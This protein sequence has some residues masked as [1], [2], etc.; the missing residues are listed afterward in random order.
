[1]K[2][3]IGVISLALIIGGGLAFYFLHNHQK[4]DDD[5]KTSATAFQVGVFSKLENANKNAQKN[6]GVVIED[7]D[8]Y[9]VYIALSTRED[10]SQK[11]SQ[12]YQKKGVNYYLKEISITPEFSETIKNYEEMLMKSSEDTYE[13][14][15]IDILKKYQ[16]RNI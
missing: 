12:Y 11:L 6:N 3:L 1:M 10:L 15:N 16:E 2:K 5:S 7:G 9:R 8:F 14:I 4:H 13:T